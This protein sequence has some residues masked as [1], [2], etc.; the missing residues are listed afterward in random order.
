MT[1]LV[2]IGIDSMDAL[3]VDAY[4]DDLPNLRR[5]KEAS[6]PIAMHSVFPPDSDTAWATIYTGL[7]PAEHGV[8]HFVD[9]LEKTSIYQTDYLDSSLVR[10]RTFWDAAGEAGKR[11]CIVNPHI[12]YPVWAVNGTMVS[13]SPKNTGVQ[14]YPETAAVIAGDGLLMPD[15][16]P[17]SKGEY[18][19]YLERLESVVRKEAAVAG[20]LM[21]STRWDLF[22]FY[23]SALDFVQHIFWNYCDPKDPMYPGDDNP[24]RDTIRH[25][26][27]TYDEIVGSL[28]TDL[29]PDTAVIVMSDHGHTMR[30][31]DLVNI[32][33]ILRM[34]GY[35]VANNGISAPI[36][37]VGE[38]A[39]RAA[40]NI[41][42]RTALRGTA[43]R[44]L[45]K[46]PGIKEYYTVPSSIDFGRT[47]A[48]CTDLSGMKAYN[49]GGI[50]IAREKLG[51]KRYDEVKREIIDLLSSYAL[52]DGVPAF[53]WVRER[54]AL[55][56]G[57][58]LEKY[59]DIL[60]KLREGYGAGWAI[61]ESVFSTSNTHSFYPGSH[62]GDTPVFFLRAPGT[63]TQA[64]TEAGLEDVSPTILEILGIG[65]DG[66]GG[67]GKSLI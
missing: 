9:P 35:L 37:N 12:G 51:E 10:G 62:R 55:Y 19:E 36:K 28:T 27:R 56:L 18:Q 60:F 14:A 26:Y 31:S 1:R 7:N 43:L 11:V 45:R 22:F 25:F 32:N 42:Q 67:S 23:S 4:L 50:L 47:V 40:V 41:I 33:E 30:P 21:R 24:F 54:E 15:R 38:K 16:I 57:R 34:K 6:P 49:Y 59:P 48:H 13:R 3:L 46:H 61:H 8:V 39:K 53:E 64:L 29:P 5:L 20:D 65:G 58:H 66:R 63:S 44:I 17:D 2:V 52:P